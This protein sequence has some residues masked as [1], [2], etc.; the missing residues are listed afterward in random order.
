M[1]DLAMM[2]S[3]IPHQA[4]CPGECNRNRRARPDAFDPI[5]GEPVWCDACARRIADAIGDL[6]DVAAGLWAIGHDEV[7]TV[8]QEVIDREVDELHRFVGALPAVIHVREVLACGHR[9]PT[10]TVRSREMIP[11]EARIRPCWQ[12][13]LDLP[14][15]DG[16]LAPASATARRSPRVLGSPAGSPS[17]LAVDEVVSWAVST[18]DYLKARL[19]GQHSATPSAKTASDEARARALTQCSAFLVE[20]IHHLLATPHARAIGREAIDLERRARRS[21]G[22][23]SPPDEQLPGVPCPGCDLVALKRRGRDPEQIVCT[24]CGRHTTD[25]EITEPEPIERGTRR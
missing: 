5:M 15:A 19:P 9:V 17:Y 1:T 10:V 2:R 23:D 13:A 4:E 6:P 8:W 21:A 24:S 12:C 18:T 22:I 11:A 14:G 25:Y 3:E 20:W 16:R 7:G